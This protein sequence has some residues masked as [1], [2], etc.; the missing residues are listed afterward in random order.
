[1]SA[2][3]GQIRRQ[4]QD[5]VAEERAELA[6]SLLESLRT[7]IADIET[8]WADEIENRVAAV[9]RGEM[10]TFPAVDVF[11]QARSLSR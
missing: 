1:M 10:E 7:P 11:A 5:L 9:D 6:V 3:L 4:A 8:A 2:S